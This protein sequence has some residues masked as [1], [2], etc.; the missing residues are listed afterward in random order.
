MP[1]LHPRSRQLGARALGDGSAHTS[2]GPQ[3]G[4]QQHPPGHEAPLTQ[5]G[6]PPLLGLWVAG[7]PWEELR[8]RLAPRRRGLG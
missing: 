5:F 4:G 8:P 3:D 7:H 2:L 1:P 6:P